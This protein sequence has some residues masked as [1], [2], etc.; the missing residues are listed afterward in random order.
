[1]ASGVFDGR[2]EGKGLMQGVDRK[3]VNSEGKCAIELGKKHPLSSNTQFIP[4]TLSKEVLFEQVE[5][6]VSSHRLE[7]AYNKHIVHVV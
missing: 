5:F 1:M 4:S 3:A 6:L 2:S 7:V